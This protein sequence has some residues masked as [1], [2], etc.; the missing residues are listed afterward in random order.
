MNSK[1]IFT[2]IFIAGLAGVILFG[3]LQA[4][5]P[6]SNDP[7]APKILISPESFDFGEIQYGDI[8]THNFG[9]T[10]S[11]KSDLEI[12]RVATSCGCTTAKISRQIIKPGESADLVVEYN[13]A[14]MGDLPENHGQQER[15]I[16]VKS[17]DPANPQ[18][19]AEISAF[20]K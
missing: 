15:I 8:V 1:I 6:A 5:A 16:Y 20:V 11:G 3:Y 4:T 12:K 13:T 7:N 2:L 9:V 19:N 17:N 18:V 14:A 10:N